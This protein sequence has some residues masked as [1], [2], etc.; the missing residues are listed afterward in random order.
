MDRV[1]NVLADSRDFLAR[2]SDPVSGWL[3]NY[4]PNDGALLFHLSNAHYRDFRP[5]LAGLGA[6][7]D[8]EHNEAAIWLRS[9]EVSARASSAGEAPTTYITLRGPRSLAFSRIGTGRHRAAH[10][11][12][13]A[14]DLWING[15][16]VVLDPGTYRYT[17]PAPWRNALTGPEVHSLALEEGASQLSVGRFLTEGMPPAELVYRSRRD[18]CEFVVS[19]RR[20]GEGRLIRAVV[21]RGDAF[22]V[23]DAA[24]GVHGRVRWNL[25]NLDGISLR[26][27]PSG[28]QNSQPQTD[29]DPTTGWVSHCYGQRLPVKV[30][31][32]PLGPRGILL[33]RLAPDDYPQLRY[34]ELQR[35]LAGTWVLER[36]PSGSETLWVSGQG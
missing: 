1:I 5:L 3:P 16:N 33:C 32:V 36:A 2:C 28:S 19:R 31:F 29:D 24:E 20:A 21:R 18:D 15:R 17:S 13:Q 34:G 35:A 23:V 6:S 11:D 8:P 22:A 30:R 25:G 4:G 7:A 14:I 12:Q 27:D 9:P 10:G 26:M